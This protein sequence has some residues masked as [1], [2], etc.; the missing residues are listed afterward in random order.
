MGGF[1]Q[2]LGGRML[3]GVEYSDVSQG[4]MVLG[5]GALDIL[6]SLADRCSDTWFSALPQGESSE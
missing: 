6:Y 5:T 2:S 3:L 4:P 1:S